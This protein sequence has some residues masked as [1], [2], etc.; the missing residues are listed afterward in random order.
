MKP[1][2]LFAGFLALLTVTAEG[3]VRPKVVHPQILAYHELLATKAGA[4]LWLT[5]DRRGAFHLDEVS[6][7]RQSLSL[8]RYPEPMGDG[9][10]IQLMNRELRSL[11]AF[12]AAVPAP[13]SSCGIEVPLVRGTW[14]LLVFDQHE[15]QRRLVAHLEIGRQLAMLASRRHLPVLG[16]APHGPAREQERELPGI[17]G[18]GEE[19]NREAPPAPH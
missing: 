16:G 13:G 2:A 10:W 4:I 17:G 8:W 1:Q 15:G 18:P 14:W 19:D 6:P 12:R 7:L 3:G 9:T 11:G 5:R